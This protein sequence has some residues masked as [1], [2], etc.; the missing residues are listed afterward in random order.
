MI[1]YIQR[2]ETCL[3]NSEIVNDMAQHFA[4]SQQMTRYLVKCPHPAPCP[5]DNPWTL[6]QT[7][8]KFCSERLA[9]HLQIK[10]TKVWKSDNCYIDCKRIYIIL[11]GTGCRGQNVT[12]CA[13]MV[14]G[15][16]LKVGML[17]GYAHKV[18]CFG[19][20]WISV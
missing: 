4:H 17:D 6:M 9:F 18:R 5:S 3:Y 2:A 1:K 15:L 7:S 11:T 20:S 14:T 16:I 13:G 8:V 12:C 10:P 19:Y